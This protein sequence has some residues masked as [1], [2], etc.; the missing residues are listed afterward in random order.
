MEFIYKKITIKSKKY[1]NIKALIYRKLK[2]GDGY[3]VIAYKDKKELS[4]LVTEDGKEI[5]PLDNMNLSGLTV[6]NEGKDICFEFMHK[7]S[8]VPESYHVKV[9]N[10]KKC[11]LAFRTNYKLEV[12]MSI[13]RLDDT[14]D[15]WLIQMG[16]DDKKYAIYDYKNLKMISN[17]F[18]EVTY[19]E[20]D[21]YHTFYYS[22][23]IESEIE[24]FDSPKEKHIHTSI[25]GFIDKD[26]NLSSQIYDI[27]SN[28]FYS[29]Y[30]YGPDTLSPRFY[31]LVKK[32]TKEYE[33]SYY[34]KSDH[35]DAVLNYMYENSNMSEKP[36]DYKNGKKILEFK[37][38]KKV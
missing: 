29:S 16:K 22:L 37:S 20:N 28:A 9:Y 11:R 3:F 34:E 8:S 1:G 13:C 10:N 21:S 23:D 6:A 5:I 36:K 12:P 32:L 26:G 4:G 25:C 19:Q 35:I 15:Y 33:K 2:Y 30:M 18:D 38:R 14:D 17:F 7:N 31:D 27:E 24:Q